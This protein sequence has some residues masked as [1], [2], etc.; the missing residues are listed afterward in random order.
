MQLVNSQDRYDVTVEIEIGA[1]VR[2]RIKEVLGNAKH[3]DVAA[4]IEMTPDAFSRSINGKRSFTAIE[5]VE[6]ARVLSTSAHWLVTGQEDPYAVRYAGRHTYD[7]EARA[8][9]VI[10]W[11][12]EHLPI[13]AVART[14]VQVADRLAPQPALPA[15]LT[16][17]Q[18]RASLLEAG[19]PEFVRSLADDVERAFGIDVVR[20]SGVNRGFAL[21]VAGNR[22]IIVN[23]TPNWFYE[24]WSIAHELSH[25]IRGELSELGD[26]ACDDPRAEIRANAFAAELLMPEDAVH[27]VNWK[28][29]APAD[30]AS[31]LWAA[32]VS[33]ESLRIRL[34]KL[35]V[36]VSDSAVTCLKAKT[37]PVIR[38]SWMEGDAE[39][40]VAL[41]IQQASSRRFPERLVAAH[42]NAVA[43]GE[44]HAGSLAWMLDVDRE[45][46]EAELAPPTE[47]VDIDWLAR[48]LGLAD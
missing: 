1:R 38:E 3:A 24:N 17:S 30:V 46:L 21:E 42:A 11:D 7:Q 28:S 36:Q 18:A 22:V 48:E 45:S 39:E 6:L 10:D 19:G 43:R 8:H 16:A 4:L 15:A 37:I 40:L 34:T 32:G 9:Q 47:P 35:K 33:T 23:E 5:L 44:L 27:A 13:A 31:Y 25:V 26:S 29:A 41:R 14:Y 20:L 12:T 2:A